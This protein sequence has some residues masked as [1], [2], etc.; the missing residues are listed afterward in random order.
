[1]LYW[2]SIR[3]WVITTSTTQWFV[4]RQFRLI[5]LQGY[6]LFRGQIGCIITRDTQLYR[7]RY[8]VLL[9]GLRCSTGFRKGYH[10]QFYVVLRIGSLILL[11]LWF[12]IFF[13]LN[14][15]AR[16]RRL[17]RVRLQLGV[18]QAVLLLG[19]RCSTGLEEG[20]SLLVIRSAT[21]ICSHI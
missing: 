11:S 4:N 12:L 7:V 3:G 15:E 14:F 1:M 16:Y 17:V 10:Y 6:F 2:R 19:I 9:P 20:L 21:E 8:A 13:V 18:R 5:L